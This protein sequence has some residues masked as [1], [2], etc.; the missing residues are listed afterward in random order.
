MGS[1]KMRATG[2][3]QSTAQVGWMEKGE[4]LK[5]TFLLFG[6]HG[7]PSAFSRGGEVP[8]GHR[9]KNSHLDLGSL[10]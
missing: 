9:R 10:V 1:E 2:S 4:V 3:G 6:Q 5:L 7:E 8:G